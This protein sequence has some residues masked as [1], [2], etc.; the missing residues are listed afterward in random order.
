VTAV[1]VLTGTLVILLTEWHRPGM[2]AGERIVTAVFQSV[3][4]ST[5]TGFNSVDIAALGLPAL[6]VLIVLMFIGASPNST[7]GGIKT[8]TLGVMSAGLWTLLKGREDV[9]LFRRRVAKKT[10]DSASSLTLAA[11]FWVMAVIG[12]MLIIEPAS[13][14]EVVFEVVSAFGNVGLSMGITP[15]LTTA[16]KILLSAT[17]FFGRLGPLAIGFSLIGKRES[18]LHRYA[19][20]DVFVG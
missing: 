16:S 15:Y 18:P 4:A 12:I 11:A 2:T 8:T 14:L 20:D 10:L 3:S 6:F 17:M 7:G 5:T 9:T 19:E 1:V 13:F